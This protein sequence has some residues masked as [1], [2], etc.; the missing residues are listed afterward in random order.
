MMWKEIFTAGHGYRERRKRGRALRLILCEV[1]ENLERCYVMSQRD[2]R[3]FLPV[4]VWVERRGVWP[5][6]PARLQRYQERLERYNACLTEF[7]TYQRW[8]S[9]DIARQSREHALILEEKKE[10]L[11]RA[12]EGLEPVV[13]AARCALQEEASA[14]F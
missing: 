1:N 4:S 3:K 8:Y 11:D 10:T 12:F 13:L 14:V 5:R 9:G 7:L 2:V 6:P